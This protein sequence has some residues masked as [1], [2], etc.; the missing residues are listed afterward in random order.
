LAIIGEA[1]VEP[2]KVENFVTEVFALHVQEY[3]P[4]GV[5]F[6]ITAN[7][8]LALPRNSSP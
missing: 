6:G 2:L 3:I 1:G 5:K 7:R 4:I 8:R